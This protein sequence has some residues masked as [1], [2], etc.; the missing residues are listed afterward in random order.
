MKLVSKGTKSRSM[1]IE[2]KT[3]ISES[4]KLYNKNI[5]D[6]KIEE[7]KKNQSKIMTKAIGRAVGQYDLEGNFIKSYDTIIQAARAVNA[8]KNGICQVISGKGK[9]CKGYIWKYLVEISQ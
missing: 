6:S 5:D 1:S 2:T 3:R 7:F 9:T 8:A 4:L